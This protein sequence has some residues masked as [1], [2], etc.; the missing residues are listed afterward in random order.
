MKINI[1]TLLSLYKEGKVQLIDIRFPEEVKAWKMGF[2]Q[3]I[4]LNELPHRLAE[5]DKNKL[6]LYKALENNDLANLKQ[7]FHTFFASIPHDWYRKNTMAGYEGYYC[8]VVYC[9]FAALGLTVRPE[10]S[11][12]HG[13]MDMVLHFQNKVYIIEFKV[14]ELTKPAQALA[15]IKEKRYHERYAGKETWLIGIEFSKEDK[16]ITRFEWEKV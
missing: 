8:S 15:Q 10:E 9:Y 1:K 13:R 16:N 12:N 14:N 11:T 2:A 6:D 5:L 3:S 7:I 4:P